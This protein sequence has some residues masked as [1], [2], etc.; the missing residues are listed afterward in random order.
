MYMYNGVY[1]WIGKWGEG[2]FDI[3]GAHGTPSLVSSLPDLYLMHALGRLGMRLQYTHQ[4]PRKQ[5]GHC[6]VIFHNPPY[7]LIWRASIM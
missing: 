7:A 4:L 6:C 2:L 5:V 1:R 3:I